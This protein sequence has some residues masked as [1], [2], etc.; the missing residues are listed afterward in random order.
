MLCGRYLQTW[1][2]LMLACRGCR[3][4]Y[5]W[6]HMDLLFRDRDR[7]N[8]CVEDYHFLSI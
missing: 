4:F 2:K 3:Q 1:W 6:H 7:Q 8:T 5:D